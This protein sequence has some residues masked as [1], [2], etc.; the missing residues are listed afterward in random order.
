MSMDDQRQAGVGEHQA[1]DELPR[2]ACL[3]LDVDQQHGQQGRR[4]HD[5][6]GRIDL[7]QPGA[8][9][10]RSP[11]EASRYWNPPITMYS[12]DRPS[13]VRLRK[14]RQHQR[15]AMT[16]ASAPSRAKLNRVHA[17]SASGGEVADYHGASRRRSD[18]AGSRT[19]LRHQCQRV[20]GRRPGSS[21]SGSPSTHA[22]CWSPN[23]AATADDRSA[24][25]G[26]CRMAVA[27]CPGDATKR[28]EAPERGETTRGV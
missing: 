11:S 23:N 14:R 8:T 2:L 27:S 20:H 26:M 9:S 24:L 25:P 21:G 15:A 3:L 7:G 5:R 18:G 6:R 16:I 19:R 4:E 17:A 1:V 10:T 22:R 28:S 12:G 13:T